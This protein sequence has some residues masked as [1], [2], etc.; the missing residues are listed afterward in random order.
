MQLTNLAK[1][2]FTEI[3][4]DAQKLLTK[5]VALLFEYSITNVLYIAKACECKTIKPSHLEAVQNVLKFY[6]GKAKGKGIAKQ[7]GGAETVLP[8]A[9]FGGTNQ[10]YFT[11][12]SSSSPIEGA[13]SNTR[14]A[15]DATFSPLLT[16]GALAAAFITAKDIKSL[17]KDMQIAVRISTEAAEIMAASINATLDTV[18]S[19]ARAYAKGK[20]K[21]TVSIVTRAANTVKHIKN[22]LKK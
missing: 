16:G 4:A 19:N 20:P 12:V 5:V 14:D 3:D 7:S 13:V 11:D 17:A 2:G 15:L 9:Y 18:L 1:Y 21:L 22:G 6:M 8:S 10:G